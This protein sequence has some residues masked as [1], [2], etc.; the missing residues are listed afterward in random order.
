MP[1]VV[2]FL[3]M[4]FYFHFHSRR[5]RKYLTSESTH[6][7]VRATVISRIDYYFFS[8]SKLVRPLANSF[9]LPQGRIQDLFKEGVVSMRVKFSPS[10]IP[11]LGT[12]K[13][14]FPEPHFVISCISFSLSCY[15]CRV[16][17]DFGSSGPGLAVE[18]LQSSTAGN[19][20]TLH[21][22][23]LVFLCFKY[24]AVDLVALRRPPFQTWIASVYDTV[25]RHLRSE[26][27]VLVCLLFIGGHF[28]PKAGDQM[29]YLFIAKVQK[30]QGILLFVHW[31][32][33]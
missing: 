28:L 19:Y 1:R 29:F 8:T 15:F 7:L 11:D 4:H 23:N 16:L 13:Q 2:V 12:L 27:Q 32:L 5:I 21:P 17:R 18:G 3:D 30:E 25:I 33:A 6:C 26:F 9:P 22:D 31:K 24:F 20:C 10:G 14:Q